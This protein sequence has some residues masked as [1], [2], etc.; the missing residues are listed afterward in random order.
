MATSQSSQPQPSTPVA[1]TSLSSAVLNTALLQLRGSA[2]ASNVGLVGDLWQQLLDAL[3]VNEAELSL[4]LLEQHGVAVLDD[5]QWSR[6]HVLRDGNALHVERMGCVVV[7]VDGR[8]YLLTPDP[9]HPNAIA[10]LNHSRLQ[11]VQLALAKA[12][13]WE[14]ALIEARGL[15][16]SPLTG[17]GGGDPTLASAQ[18]TKVLEQTDIVQFVDDIILQAYQEGASDIHFETHRAGLAVKYR[19]DGV[20]AQGARLNNLQQSE[21]VVSRIKVMA[22]LDITER[23]RPQDGRIHWSRPG[24]AALDLRVSVMP[25]IFGEDVVLRLLDKAQLKQSAP[26]DALAGSV[27]PV[28]EQNLTLNMLGFEGEEASQ[29]RELAAR[30]HG[31]LLITGPTG[32]GKTTTVYAAMSEVNDGLEKIVTIEDPVEYELSGVLQIPVNEQKGLTFATGLRSILRHDP[33]K[34][35]VGEIRDAETAQIAVQSSLTGHLVFT[36]VHANSLFDVL[37][38]FQ[39][40]GIEPFALASA[41][42]GVVVQRLMRKLCPHCQ[43]LRAPTDAE[44]QKLKALE[45]QVPTQFPVAV[46]CEQCRHTGYRGRFVVAEVHVLTDAVRDLIV[47]QASMLELRSALYANSSARLLARSVAHVAAGHT[48][49]EEVSRVVGLV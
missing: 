47:R 35:L 23:R 49:L 17:S 30:P 7:G 16:M 10:A 15:D 40:F 19:L 48:T 24:L 20:M 22:Q 1:T 45:L 42:N 21:E 6:A 44:V 32:S 11:D 36:T 41:L 18:P 25:S 33:D 38:R 13:Q 26:G 37:G 34:I 4:A 28:A 2:A 31:M 12:G 5:S 43:D 39:H 46:G 3:K 14:H 8:T 29:L 9:W 27:H